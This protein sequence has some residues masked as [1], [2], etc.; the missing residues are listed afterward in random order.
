[1]KAARYTVAPIPVSTSPKLYV[2]ARFSSMKQEDGDSID[3]QM[4]YARRYATDH[5]LTLD[6]EFVLFDRGQSAFTGKNV[7]HGEL[8][9]FLELIKNGRIAKG[10]G[11]MVENIDRLTRGDMMQGLVLVES[12]VKE[13]VNLIVSGSNKTITGEDLRKDA[14]T[15]IG[16]VLEIHRGNGESSRKSD[17]ITESLIGKCESWLAGEYRFS[18]RGQIGSG[19]HP[20]WIEWDS[21]ARTYRLLEDKVAAIRAAIALYR[22]GH[23]TILIARRLEEAGLELTGSANGMPRTIRHTLMLPALMGTRTIETGKRRGKETDQSKIRKFPLPGYYPA[24]LTPDEYASLQQVRGQRRTDGLK[25]DLVAVLTGTRITLCGHCGRPMTAQN[26]M[27]RMT[28]ARVETGRLSAG[29]RRMM[30]ASYVHNTPCPH[31][32][33]IQTHLLENAIMECCSVDFNL[34]HLMKVDT[35][36]DGLIAR[37][38]RVR[39]EMAELEAE[40]DR[41]GK[42]AL[43]AKDEEQSDLWMTRE[44]DAMRAIRKLT[45]ESDALDHQ[46]RALEG[47]SE[48]ATADVWGSLIDGINALDADVRT[49]AR[50]LVADTFESIRVYNGGYEGGQPELV[51]VLLKS[52]RGASIAL[53]I[54]RKT[55][56]WRA[57]CIDDLKRPVLRRGQKAAA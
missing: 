9:K 49:S 34:A 25:G 8:G 15:M 53:R 39:E 28:R 38:V 10:S 13:G 43:R 18:E 21:E 20:Y 57:E 12:I 54:T 47:S 17:M 19:S 41:C 6:E 48:T 37:A 1:M 23:G 52:K 44:A 33:T 3:R 22:A 7:T 5:G 4:R 27:N 45:K 14:A 16:L 30:C 55:G 36:H 35:R 29:Q 46:V 11:F 42:L 31:R 26:Q 40:R 24:I 56:E 50:K 2:Y 32:G 51:D